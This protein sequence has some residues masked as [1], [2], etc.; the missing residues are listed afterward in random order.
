MFEHAITHGTLP[1]HQSSGK[2]GT[3][4]YPLHP[5]SPPFLFPPCL[6]HFSSGMTCSS[7]SKMSYPLV[8]R[9]LHLLVSMMTKLPGFRM[10]P[11]VNW[12]NLSVCLSTVMNPLEGY[13]AYFSPRSGQATEPIKWDLYST[14]PFGECKVYDLCG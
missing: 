2:F 5:S 1:V 6:N 10:G 14:Q 9:S 7:I 3:S 4:F 8:F 12:E 13:G 11:H